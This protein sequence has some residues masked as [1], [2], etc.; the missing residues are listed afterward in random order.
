MYETVGGAVRRRYTLNVFEHKFGQFFARGHR[1]RNIY[2]EARR[3]IFEFGHELFELF[4]DLA[5]IVRKY[6]AM[7]S[8]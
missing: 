2:A 6:C 1:Q 7:E 3:E 5:S 4:A 8:A